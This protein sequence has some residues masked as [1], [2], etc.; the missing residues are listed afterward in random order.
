[1]NSVGG[2][3]TFVRTVF[4]RNSG[5]TGGALRLAGTTSIDDCH[6]V[7][8]ISDEGEGAAISNIGVVNIRG[9]NTF[10]G[11]TYNCE[12]SMYLDYMEV[13][14]PFEAICDGCEIECTNCVFSEGTVEPICSIVL[15]HSISIGGQTTLEDISIEDGFWRATTC[16]LYTSDAADE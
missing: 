11:N 16:L 5:G 8:N 2:T 9:N 12:N 3:E 10:S 4:D 14:N 1:M 15:D 13:D 7:E 6:F